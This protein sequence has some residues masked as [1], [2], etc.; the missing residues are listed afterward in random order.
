MFTIQAKKDH[1]FEQADRLQASLNAL[2]VEVD[3][4][5]RAWEASFAYLE[6]SWRVRE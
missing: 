2:G 1:R 5:R 6:S 4:K 3:D